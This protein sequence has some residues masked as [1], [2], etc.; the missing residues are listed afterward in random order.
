[1]RR[2]DFRERQAFLMQRWCAEKKR[3]IKFQFTYEEWVAWWEKHLGP[4]WFEKRGPQFNKY[5]MAR[6]GDKGP[7]AP[8]NVKCILAGEN[9]DERLSREGH[10]RHSYV[11]VVDVVRGRQSKYP[12]R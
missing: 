11:P 6:Y 4:D 2:K 5:V 7:Y 9:I 3:G 1:M 10:G 8:W 12:K